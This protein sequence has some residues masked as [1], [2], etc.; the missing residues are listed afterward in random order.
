MQD[1]ES[2]FYPGG[3]QALQA[4]YT[5]SFGFHGITGG[6]WLKKTY[7]SYGSKAHAYIFSADRNIFYP[8]DSNHRVREQVKK[9][10]FYGRPSTPRRAYE[11]GIKALE[12]ISNHYP[13]IEI[14]I[15]GHNTLAPPKFKCTL[16]GNLTLKQT[17]ELYRTCDIG[18]ALSGTNMSYLPVELM[19]SGCPVVC[20]TGPQVDWYCKDGYNAL[21]VDPVPTRFLTAVKKLVESRELRQSLVDNGRETIQKTT[22]DDE[23]EKVFQYIQHEIKSSE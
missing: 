8:E 19:A 18:I 6:H 15:A 2:M 14:L 5:Y 12:L 23:M 20:N 3:T 4:N 9:I 11:L 10:F 13:D 21:L 1:Y 17:G 7:E 22:W 16:L